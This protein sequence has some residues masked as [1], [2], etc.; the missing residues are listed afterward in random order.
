MKCKANDNICDE[1]FS[2]FLTYEV[3]IQP[4]ETT[5]LISVIVASFVYLTVV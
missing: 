4:V 2:F 1:L 5:Y 3:N